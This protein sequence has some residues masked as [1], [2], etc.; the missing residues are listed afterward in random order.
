MSGLWAFSDSDWL[1]H[2]LRSQSALRF[3][4]YACYYS[5]PWAQNPLENPFPQMRH[6]ILRQGENPFWPDES[7]SIREVLGL[8]YGWPRSEQDG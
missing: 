8:P 3:P 5:N 7:A 2:S 1:K 6:C 4:R